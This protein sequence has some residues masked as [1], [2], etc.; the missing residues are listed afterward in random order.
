MLDKLKTPFLIIATGA[1]IFLSVFVAY[2]SANYA[3]GFAA[4]GLLGL[5]L[6]AQI[7][8]VLALLGFWIFKK[9]KDC[10]FAAIIIICVFFITHYI[11]GKH[12]QSLHVLSQSQ[13]NQIILAV[14]KY[15]QAKGRLPFTLKELVPAYLDSIP[16]PK[17]QRSSY[18]YNTNNEKTDFWVGY[19]APAW[20]LCERSPNSAWVCDD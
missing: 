12:R 18:Y 2:V 8:F 15:H 19:H 20:L 6:L 10:I 14:N 1:M 9:Q 16:H 3:L 4:T 5:L 11:S 17:F 13:G 7:F